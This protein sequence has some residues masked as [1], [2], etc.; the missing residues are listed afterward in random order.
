MEGNL[1]GGSSDVA[2][3]HVKTEA[4]DENTPA[5]VLGSHESPA[6]CGDTACKGGGGGG[7]VDQTAEEL[8]DTELQAAT[9]TTPVLLCE[10]TRVDYSA[11]NIWGS[12]F[13]SVTFQ[14]TDTLLICCSVCVT[15]R[16]CG[17]R[18][19]LHHIRRWK[20]IPEDSSR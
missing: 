20:N 11:F 5:L 19:V 16:S 18:P 8:A 14:M 7:G 3:M 4:A 12:L 17:H 10:C 15:I 6:P 2:V 13:I 1:H 9:T